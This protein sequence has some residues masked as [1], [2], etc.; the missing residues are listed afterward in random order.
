ML[1]DKCSLHTA[2]NQGCPLNGDRDQDGIIDGIDRC[3]DEYGLAIHEGCPSE[4]AMAT[5]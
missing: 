3:P 2:E 1:L 5:Q 4:D